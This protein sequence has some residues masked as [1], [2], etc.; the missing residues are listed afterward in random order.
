MPSRWHKDGLSFWAIREVLE[1]CRDYF[2]HFSG[3]SLVEAFL[4]QDEMLGGK[5]CQAGR[6]ARRDD[7]PS[8]MSY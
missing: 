5:N 6:A 7:L 2:G 4:R 1:I 8:R 3:D